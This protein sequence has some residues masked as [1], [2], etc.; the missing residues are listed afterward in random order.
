[1]VRVVGSENVCS[2][3][4]DVIIVVHC[5]GMLDCLVSDV[6]NVCRGAVFGVLIEAISGFSWGVWLYSV[7]V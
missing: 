2:W 4:W 7:L 6:G 5:C 1:M 3:V